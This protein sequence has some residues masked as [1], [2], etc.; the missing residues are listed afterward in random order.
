MDKIEEFVEL[1]WQREMTDEER[2]EYFGEIYRRF[3]KNPRLSYEYGGVFDYLGIEE[4]AIPLYNEA[5][6]GG[7]SGSF[8]IKALIQLG[9]SYRNVGRYRE[10]QEVLEIALRESE[11]DP[12]AVI[13]LSLTL[14]SS[15]KSSEAA[16]LALRHI[17][18]GDGELLHRYRKPIGSYL[19]E[20]EG[21]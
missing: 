17:Y 6:E 21:K 9:S 3:P 4:K 8:R 14:L 19:K 11:N 15:G 18:N 20:I 1:G 13:F 12:A 10:S 16:L 7:L 2:L 5:I